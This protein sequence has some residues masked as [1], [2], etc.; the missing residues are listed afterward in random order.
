[1]DIFGLG[2]IAQAAGQVAAASIQA[3]AIKDATQM[4]IDALQQQRQF[5]FDNLNPNT[6]QANATRADIQNANARLALQGQI[7]PALLQARYQ[8]ESSIANQQQ[9]LGQQSQQ[10]MNQ[11]TS[12]ALQQSPGM[13]DA[14][15]KM[16]DSALSQLK[17]GATLPPDVEAQLVQSGLEQSGMVTQGASAQGIG[18]QQ[19]RTILGTAGIQLQQQRQQQAAS[20]LG[21]AQNLTASRAN[22][23]NSLFPTLSATQ[24]NNL[25]GQQN[26]LNQSNNMV[27]QAGLNGQGIT[28]I[29]L[30][31]VGA[32]NALAQQQATVGAQGIMGTANA[33]GNAAGALGSGI[34]NA[35][36]MISGWV[37][38]GTNNGVQQGLNWVQDTSGLDTSGW[39]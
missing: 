21:Q 35:V 32:A 1:M 18:G 39:Q 23:L 31:R 28:N 29:M 22:I 25:T 6:V 26:V 20:L 36:P 12:E 34:G 2:G 14:K 19:L 4:Q 16:I 38:G 13:Q 33:W 10:I 11:A 3:S 7:D 8:A 30:A 27:P 37:N 15:N 9:N 17:A 5:L 24:L